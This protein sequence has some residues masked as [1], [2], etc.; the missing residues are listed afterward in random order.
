MSFRRDSDKARRW[1]RFLDAN[2]G[3]VIAAG[4]MDPH[5]E[6]EERFAD[7]LMHGYLDHHEDTTEFTVDD[8]S[9]PQYDAFKKL[10]ARYFECGYPYFTAM[11]LRTSEDQQEIERTFGGE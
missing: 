2:R 3:L 11:A 7:F 1:N 5:T 6:T 9:A 8:L 10:V 4:L